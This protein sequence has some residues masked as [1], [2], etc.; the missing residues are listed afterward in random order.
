MLEINKIHNMDCLEGMKQFK[1]HSFDVVISDPPYNV[2]IDE[3]DKIED[4]RLFCK[5]WM[6]EVIRITKPNKAIWIFGNQHSTHILREILDNHKDIRFRSQV[7]WNKGV[8]IPSSHNFSNL[9]EQ[10]LYYIKVP[11]PK[12]LKN[13]GYYIKKKRKKLNLSL[14]EIGTLCSEKWYHRGGHLYFETGLVIPTVEQYLK[15]KEVLKLNNTYDVYFD[16]HFIFNLESIGVKW[17]YEKDKRNKRGWKNCGDVWN[18]PQLSGTFKERLNHPTQK[19][20]NLLRRMLHVSSNE[21]DLVLDLFS[22]TGTTSIVSKQLRRRFI[23]FELEDKYIKIAN[24]RLK[25]EVLTFDSYESNKPEVDSSQPLVDKQEGGNGIP[26][27]NKLVGILPKI[28]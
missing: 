8:G 21:G 18:I 23:G 27:T 24:K 14:K 7:I 13:F 12:I 20:I 3:W 16:N 5:E 19:P 9:Y 25:Q 26:P 1:E 10:I 11:S 6:E 4:Y 15:L 2:G 28:L 22:G 17:K